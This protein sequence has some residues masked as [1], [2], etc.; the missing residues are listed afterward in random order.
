M[1]AVVKKPYSSHL[2]R[3]LA[4]TRFSSDTLHHVYLL[5]DL[6]FHM[7]IFPCFS[8]LLLADGLPSHGS[9]VQGAESGPAQL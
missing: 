7:Y 3:V 8:E 9:A 6:S 5:F 4:G 2:H 1:R